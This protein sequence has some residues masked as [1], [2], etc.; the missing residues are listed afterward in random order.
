MLALLEKF[1]P[2]GLRLQKHVSF[3]DVEPDALED[4]FAASDLEGSPMRPTTSKPQEGIHTPGSSKM[5]SGDKNNTKWLEK[6]HKGICIGG[7]KRRHRRPETVSIPTSTTQNL[8]ELSVTLNVLNLS[9][10]SLSED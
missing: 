9:D 7:K 8:G 4:T 1:I 5:A 6:R 10:R 3:S 2:G